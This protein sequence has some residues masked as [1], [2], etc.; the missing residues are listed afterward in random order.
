MGVFLNVLFTG[1]NFIEDTL[2]LSQTQL[3]NISQDGPDIRLWMR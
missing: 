1:Q 2:S 3:S